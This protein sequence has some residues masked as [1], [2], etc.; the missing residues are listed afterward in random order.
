MFLVTAVAAGLAG[1][2]P[3]DNYDDALWRRLAQVPVLVDIGDWWR[4][5]TAAFVHVGLVHL[6]L[7]M[8][9]L[10]VFGSELERA[11]G[12]WRYLGVYLVA[13]LGG[14]AAIQ[15]FGNPV[16]AVAGASTAIYGLLGALGV[17]LL[18][19]R[20]SLRG[21]VTLLVLNIV[22]SVV[23]PGISILGH[24]GGLVAGAAAAGVVVL[25]RRRGALQAAGLVVLGVALLV[26][27][28]VVPVGS[29]GGY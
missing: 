22:I 9:A 17:L 16:Q 8:L 13:L 26:L 7:N 18:A 1:A 21:L 20:Q 14:A 29:L 4:L 12:R 28:L 2:N 10:L 24:L 5:V 23:V 27:A 19:G 25:A 3:L 15:L 6:V 11:L